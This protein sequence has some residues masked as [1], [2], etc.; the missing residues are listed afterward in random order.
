MTAV[1]ISGLR[2]DAY[3]RVAS[4]LWAVAFPPQHDVEATGL[5]PSVLLRRGDRLMRVD[6]FTPDAAVVAGVGEGTAA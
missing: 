6:P 1:E 3:V 2:V 4:G 5:V